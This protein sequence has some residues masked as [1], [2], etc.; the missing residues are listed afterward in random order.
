MLP[1][2][3]SLKLNSNVETVEVKVGGVSQSGPEVYPLGD[4]LFRTDS[5]LPKVPEFEMSGKRK[6]VG[7]DTEQRFASFCTVDVLG[8][9]KGQ[10]LR[11]LEDR[12]N[13]S[14]ICRVDAKTLAL[15]SG[16]VLEVVEGG[17]KPQKEARDAAIASYGI[18][19]WAA[20]LGNVWSVSNAR[21][22]QLIEMMDDSMSVGEE[23]YMGVAGSLVQAGS[24]Q[25]HVVGGEEIRFKVVEPGVWSIYDEIVKFVDEETFVSPAVLYHALN[26]GKKA[27][28][29]MLDSAGKKMELP[30]PFAMR[31]FLFVQ[32]ASSGAV[33]HREG[34]KIDITVSG[35][36]CGAQN[37]AYYDL[38]AEFQADG[39]HTKLRAVLP[40]SATSTFTIDDAVAASYACVD[41]L[42]GSGH[43]L[44]SGITAY[45]LKSDLDAVFE[46]LKKPSIGAGALKSLLQKAVRYGAAKTSLPDEAVVDTRAVVIAC[47]GALYAIK[48]SFV[49]DLGT[50]VRGCTA[51]SK[52][53]GVIVVEDAWPKQELLKDLGDLNGMGETSPGK[54][55]EALMG[56][57][58]AT[59]RLSSYQPPVEII[60]STMIVMVASHQSNQII[61]WRPKTGSASTITA[62]TYKPG[63]AMGARLLRIVRSFGGDMDMLDKAA[64]MTSD[65]G[66]V[67]VL[68]VTMDKTAVMPMKHMIDFHVYRGAA[69]VT[70]NGSK[71]FALRHSTMFDRCT[72]TNPRIAGG[73]MLDEENAVIRVVRNQ[74]SMIQELLFPQPSSPMDEDADATL[75]VPLD[76]GVLSAGVGPIGPLT[77]RTTAAENLSDGYAKDGAATWK[78]LVILGVDNEDEIVMHTVNVRDNDKKPTITAT[79][80]RKA[81]LAARGMTHKFTSPVLRG[82]SKVQYQT[83]DWV[84]LPTEA[85]GLSPITWNYDTPYNIDVPY[86]TIAEVPTAQLASFPSV[87]MFDMLKECIALS[88]SPV[89]GLAANYT[90]SIA[91]IMEALFR[92]ATEQG[93]SPR[94]LQ[95]R[96]LGLIRGK[97]DE[98][99]LPLPAKDGGIGADQLLAVEGDWLVYL[100]LL[101]LARVAPGALRLKMAP[102]FDVV[103]SRVLRKIEMAIADQLASTPDVA[104][105]DKFTSAR[106]SLSARYG[107]PLPYVPKDPEASKFYG[108]PFDYQSDLVKKML[109]RDKDAV[110]KP[111]GHF[112][113]LDTGLGKSLVALMYALEYGATYGNATRVIWFTPKSVVETA[114]AELKTTWGMGVAAVGKVDRLSPNLNRLINIVSTGDLS[115][116]NRV[117]LETELVRKAETSIIIVDEVHL[118]YNVSIRTSTI[119]NVI[120]ACPRF[121]CM[122]AT[123]TPSRG[124]VIGER[125]IADSVGFPLTKSNFL[126][127]A[128]QMVAAR[129]SL[130]IVAHERLAPVTLSLGDAATHIRFLK[131]GGKWNEAAQ[132]VRRACFSVMAQKI[133]EV[134]DADRIAF[135]TGGVLVFMDNSEEVQIMKTRLN[136]MVAGKGYTVGDR[137]GNETNGTVGIAIT[138]KSDTAGYNFI[139]AGAIV[140]GVYA[141]SAASRHQL[142]GRIRRVGQKRTD[143]D[144]YTIYPTKTI[145]SMLF[146]RHNGVDQKNATLEQLA[147]EFVKKAK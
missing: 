59:T 33:E 93:F 51:A 137:A 119:R 97:Y 128:A 27:L 95:L 22:A 130:P 142:R 136:S 48:S 135:P 7:S 138:T 12:D 8:A 74:Q 73:K 131:D 2:L 25:M 80:K 99:A 62:A 133:V 58:L 57:A 41:R 109:K 49:P 47:V 9:T 53:A 39:S 92:K 38:S 118:L 24:A 143:V 125:W 56:V 19:G 113:S 110:V 70:A 91:S 42:A 87:G 66:L 78:L 5:L 122:T 116:A 104:W 114:L 126:V 16:V 106:D 65:A 18:D 21:A 105:K 34:D 45:A 81:I 26:D 98:V 31:R 123:P 140:T 30:G 85:S 94:T 147:V 23:G 32:A 124:Q 90:A 84:V 139:R 10:L 132:H 35:V 37:H 120:E 20:K 88:S 117:A 55:L 79:A 44:L 141:Q 61:D 111:H 101:K 71:T 89:P 127:G 69:F 46:V 1:S 134:A 64:A 54:A 115:V 52:R 107:T 60:L 4:R 86:K 146:E 83:G 72:G 40:R 77:I 112:V 36:L 76:Y 100:S 145:L 29:G 3:S 67:Q 129:V 75:Q 17:V 121:I 63:M 43:G 11:G 28:D 15:V 14:G 50:H 102:K 6:E 68:D 144:Y 108:E 13:V 103:D 82:Y 96:L